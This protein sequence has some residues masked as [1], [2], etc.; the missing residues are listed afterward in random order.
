MLDSTQAVQEG[1]PMSREALAAVLQRLPQL[2]DRLRLTAEEG[3]ELVA[4]DALL[5]HVE[6]HRVG[7]A[8][9]ALT[10]PMAPDQ[11]L[12][13]LYGMDL[14]LDL[15]RRRAPSGWLFRP[16]APLPLQGRGPAAGQPGQRPQPPR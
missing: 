10:P 4:D 9:H 1:G 13:L 11:L 2:N 6:Q 5:V 14:A 12:G 15:D 8:P 7:R 16:A 3:L